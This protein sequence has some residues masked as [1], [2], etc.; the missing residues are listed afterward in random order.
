MQR[1]WTWAGLVAQVAFVAGWLGAATWQPTGYSV[2]RHSISDMY[3]VTAPHAWYLVVLLTAC[4]AAT[5]GFAWFA[6]RPALRTGG[7]R[8]TVGSA[9]LALSIF[10]LG[11]LL[12]P[13]EQEAC[14]QADPG[15]S[16]ADQLA[17]LGGT[18]DGV[19]STVGVLAGVAAGFVLASAMR[20]APGW[21]SCV[22]PARVVT[23]VFVV[24]FLATGFLGGAL[25]LGGLF[26]RLLAVVGA[27]G[28][29]LLA[30]AVLRRADRATAGGARFRSGDVQS[31]R[32]P[33]ASTEGPTR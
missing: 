4:G 17:N 20:R 10:G 25:G 31:A 8:A 13:L 23:V 2:L 5:T 6:V 27:A 22:R 19:L 12:S 9:L 32:P 16:P 30:V 7:R 29:A 3:A 14:Q 28:I 18:L 11:D 26:E 33:A 24:T 1:A 15:C 21:S